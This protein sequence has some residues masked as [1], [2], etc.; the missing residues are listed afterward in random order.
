MIVMTTV[1]YLLI[2]HS[3]L[4][5]LTNHLQCKATPVMEKIQHKSIFPR[6]VSSQ[7]HAHSARMSSL[8]HSKSRDPKLFSA[9]SIVV[10][11]DCSYRINKVCLE[12]C[13]IQGCSIVYG[14][15]TL[16]SLSDAAKL[17]SSTIITVLGI[18]GY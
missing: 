13:S 18:A 17:S 4:L 9:F 10:Q 2:G 5:K 16:V 1:D 8:F 12:V 3:A 14:F 7:N 15:S 11:F 6:M